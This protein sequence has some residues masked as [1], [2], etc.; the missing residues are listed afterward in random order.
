MVNSNSNLY[1]RKIIIIKTESFIYLTKY[2]KSSSN[3]H[4]K[5]NKLETF[6]K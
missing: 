5:L 1:K 2:K 6:K 3:Y 4:F